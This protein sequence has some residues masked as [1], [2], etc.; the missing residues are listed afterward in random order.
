LAKKPKILIVDDEPALRELIIFFLMEN[1][2][3]EYIEQ[4]NGKEAVEYLKRAIVI[5]DLPDLCISDMNMPQGNGELLFNFIQANLPNLPFILS[6][7]DDWFDYPHFHKANTA[8]L[9]KPFDEQNIIIAVNKLLVASRP[10]QKAD[11]ESQ[12]IGITLCMLKSLSI[13]DCVLYLKLS[14]NNYV[15]VILPGTLFD[16]TKFTEFKNKNATHLFVKKEDYDLLIKNFAEKINL[17]LIRN[18]FLDTPFEKIEFAGKSIDLISEAIKSFGWCIE[19]EEFAKKQI[20]IVVQFIKSQKQLSS[21]L[22]ELQSPK[23]NFLTT[24]SLL[25]AF[26]G[27]ALLHELESSEDEIFILILAAFF[28]DVSLEPNLCQNEPKLLA[29]LKLNRGANKEEKYILLSHPKV[30]VEIT[31]RLS[32]FPAQAKKIIEQHHEKP[33][34]SGYP[35]GITANAISTLAAIFIVAEEFTFKFLS[36]GAS[37]ELKSEWLK[38]KGLYSSAPFNKYF[39]IIN[40]WK[41]QN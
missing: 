22:N 29:S 40:N 27:T 34:G 1:L 37:A 16:E 23:S 4:G 19:V 7:S 6:T 10:P 2:D 11:Y 33:D 9:Q 26:I 24:H 30:S 5:N 14:E 3:A 8:Y 32:F 35:D 31:N 25:I 36:F 28:H 39:E 18:C 21:F 12:F 13:I 41:N 20:A 15:K 38:L 17:R